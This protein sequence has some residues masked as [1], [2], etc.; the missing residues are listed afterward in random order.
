MRGLFKP[1]CFFHWKQC[2]ATLKAHLKLSAVWSL[3][4][5][6]KLTYD[7]NARKIQSCWA[8]SSIQVAFLGS[9]S[10]R[11]RGK[12]V[13]GALSRHEVTVHGDLFHRKRSCG[14]RKQYKTSPESFASDTTVTIKPAYHTCSITHS[15]PHLGWDYFQGSQ[16]MS[17]RAY[18]H[19][20]WLKSPHRTWNMDAKAANTLLNSWKC[21]RF[22]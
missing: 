10:S 1:K 20:A 4:S 11:C 12:I 15:M 21:S 9:V 13:C 18:S 3:N 17:I 6:T 19:D 22:F 8:C 2:Y 7:F 5:D 14:P 16:N